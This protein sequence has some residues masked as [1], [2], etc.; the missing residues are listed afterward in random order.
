MTYV[1]IGDADLSYVPGMDAVVD[2]SGVPGQ[3]LG[4]GTGVIAGPLLNGRLRWSFFEE[5]CSWDPGVLLADRTATTPAGRSVC[6]TYPRGLIE[7]DEGNLVQFEG[8]GFALRSDDSPI[9]LVGS[10]VRFVTQSTT[11]RWLMS[12]LVAYDGRFD[13]RHGTAN[14]SFHAPR[15]MI[16]GAS[17]RP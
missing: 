3:L 6:C 4:S 14:W 13:E 10:T 7:T 15:H 5:V 11:H 16:E 2:P 12:G 9:W 1:H 17:L 8:Q